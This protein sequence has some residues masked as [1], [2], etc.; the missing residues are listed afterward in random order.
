VIEKRSGA[1]RRRFFRIDDRLQLAVHRLPGAD[2]GAGAGGDFGADEFLAGIDRGIAAIIAAAR[3]QAPAVGELAQL[4]NR[5]LDYVIERLGQLEAPRARPPLAEHEVSISACGLGLQSA[6]RYETGETLQVELMLPP[7]DTR[8]CV[9]ARV[10]RCRDAAHGNYR[11]QLDFA[12]MGHDDQ[13]L[14]IRFIMRRQGQFL[15]GLR[16]QRDARRTRAAS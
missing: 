15:Q 7:D 14:L 12:G 10:V 1:D 13:E 9:P 3:V 11:L 5:K 16:E 4:L 8:L 6:E 2:E